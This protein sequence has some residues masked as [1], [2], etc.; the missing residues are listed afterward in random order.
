M[1]LQV[2]IGNDW[3]WVFC[4]NANRNEIITTENRKKALP[5]MDIEY[6]RRKFGNDEFRVAGKEQ[7]K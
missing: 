1:K 4:R 3:K 7:G 5:A 6:F 2:K